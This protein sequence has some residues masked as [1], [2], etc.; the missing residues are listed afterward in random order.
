MVY[1]RSVLTYCSR[2]CKDQRKLK[3]KSIIQT[4]FEVNRRNST[5]NKLA[6]KQAL[7][8]GELRE[9][10]RE[11]HGSPLIP[12]LTALQLAAARVLAARSQ[13]ND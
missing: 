13:A 12:S 3:Q 6:C 9:V 7:H 1:G 2:P 8:L 4:R 10:T 11:S 5:K